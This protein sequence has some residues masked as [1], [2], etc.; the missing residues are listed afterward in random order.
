[1]T[2]R[3]SIAI[4]GAGFFGLCSAL[5]LVE[6][7]HKVTIYERN[8]KAMQE[9]S[10]F[11]QARV[12]GGYHYPR[13]MSTAARSR[14]NYQRFVNQYNEAIVQDFQSIY[15]IAKDS[16]V[17]SQKFSRL[18]RIIDAPI[19]NCSGSLSREFNGSLIASAVRV[20]EVAFNSTILCTLI[21]QKLQQFDIE[22]KYGCNIVE[23]KNVRLGGV[24]CVQIQPEV[25]TS[26]IQDCVI[27]T[28]YGLDNINGENGFNSKYL[29][30][31]CELVS[32]NP[33]NLLKNI[34]ITVMDGPY[35]S[36]TP[37]PAFQS[38]VLTHVRHTPHA[39]F[40]NFVEAKNFLDHADN[41]RAEMMIRDAARYLPRMAESK[42]LDRKF[43]I[44]TILKERD[45]N[46]ARPIFIQ[47][48]NRILSILGSKIDNV[49]D[50]SFVLE[51]FMKGI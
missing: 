29:Y 33:P 22:F 10:L 18:M 24:E 19:T 14:A 51:E 5:E 42:I 3:K 47:R 21:I 34:A 9:A 7:G 8:P 43:T 13:S 32:I 11:N 50:V 38:H 39:R 40:H 27:L 48:S 20:N 16:K 6:K 44:K 4:I 15:A 1:M 41:S 31:V 28:T 36:L 46:D 45:H 25:G 30:E 23:I 49:Y 12:H 17:N 26:E 35:W 37:W 2:H